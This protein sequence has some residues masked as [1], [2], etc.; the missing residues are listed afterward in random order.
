MWAYYNCEAMGIRD[1][2]TFETE[3]DAIKFVRLATER[4]M[5]D[6]PNEPD[7]WTLLDE[8][9]GMYIFK[10]PAPMSAEET[11]AHWFGD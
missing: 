5:K 10:I 6:Y 8:D 11:L 3:E 1:I 7:M 9:E 2:Y 4:Y